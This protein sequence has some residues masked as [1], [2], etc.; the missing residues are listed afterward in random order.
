MSHRID[1]EE[2]R[3]I[4]AAAGELAARLA[5][6]ALDGRITREEAAALLPLAERVVAGVRAA[7]ED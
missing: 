7:L 4:L 6:A 2:W 1:R 3:P 5:L